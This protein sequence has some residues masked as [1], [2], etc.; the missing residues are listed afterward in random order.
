MRFVHGH[1]TPRIPIAQRFWSKVDKSDGCWLWTAGRTKLGYG[2]I[3]NRQGGSK[4][5]HRT[6]WTLMHGPIPPG[7]GVCHNCPDGDNPSCVRCDGPLT[8]YWVN[9]IAYPCHGHLW[10]GPPA[11]N[12]ADKIAKGRDAHG[13][14][15][16]QARLTT[17]QVVEM[18]F[19]RAQDSQHWTYER[20]GAR[21]GVS[22]T[23]AY[24]VCAGKRWKHVS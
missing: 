1:N 24:K 17:L 14:E 22:F 20:L 15:L 18:R 21:Y 8:E 6:A 10:L 9:G 23:T 16:P 11:A 2:I 13:E 19:L 12:M 7:L 5:A 4:L 3:G